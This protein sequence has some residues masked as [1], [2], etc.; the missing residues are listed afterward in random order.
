MNSFLKQVADHYYSLGDI[1]RRCFVFPNRRS[2]VFFSKYLC[3]AVRGKTPIVAPQMLTI[4]DMFYKVAGLFASDRVRLLLE[5]YE[6]YRELNPKAESLDEF[7]FWGDVILADF[8]DVDKYLVDPSQLFTNISDYKSLQDTFEY[9]TPTQKTAIE[10]FISHFN[11]KSGR[12]TVKLDTDNPDVKGRFLQIWNI[13]YP[14]YISFRETLRSK[15]MAYE[16]MV[17]KDLSDRLKSESVE[18]VFN[19]VFKVDA[20]FVFVGLNALS[21][22]EKMLL[23]K[24]RDAGRAQFCWDWSGDIIRDLQNRASFFMAD[25]VVEFPQAAQWDPEGVTVPTVNVV[26]VSSMIGQAKRLPDILGEIAS[27]RYSGDLSCIGSDCAVV[28][29][30]ENLL[31]PVLNSIPE[32][33]KDINVTMGLP[34][35]GSLLYALMSD[36][37]SVQLNVIRRKGKCWF[38][39]KHVWDVFSSEVFRKIA[40]QQTLDQIARVRAEARHYIPEDDFRNTPLLSAIFRPVVDDSKTASAE[41]IHSFAEYQKDVLR[42]LAQKLVDDSALALELEYAREYY[43]C[44]NVLQ[45]IRLEVLPVTYCRLLNQLL[46]AVSV[47]FNGEPLRGLQIMGPLEM[48]ALDFKDL[49]IMSANEGTFPRRSVSSSFVPPELRKG[50][51]MPTYEYQDAVWAYYFY[52][53]ISRAENVWMLVDSRTEG[54]KSGEESRYIKQLEYHFGVPI[55]RYVVKYDNMKTAQLS[56]IVKTDEDVQKVKETALSA[57][58]LQNYLACPAKFYYSTVKGLRADEE[59]AESLDYGMFGTIFH[60]TMRS[61]YTGEEAMNVDFFFDPRDSLRGL[62]EEPLKYVTREYIKSWLSRDEELRAK[63]KA[64]IMNEMNVLEISGRNLVVADV[65]LKYVKKTLN[66]DLELLRENDASHFVMH[67]LENRFARTMFGQ[68]FKGYIDR[69][70]SVKDGEVRVVDYKTGKVLENDENISDGNAVEI[71]DMI[72][73]PSCKER[74]KIALQFFIYDMLIQSDPRFEGLTIANSVYSTANL[75]KDKPQIKPLCRKFY[76]AMSEHMEKLLEEIYDLNVP[77]RR[78]DDEKVCAYC[79]FKMICGR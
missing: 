36:I 39:H 68:K 58:T 37:S 8:N 78:T 26:S 28:L 27:E 47:P 3:E 42:M 67:G 51:G 30:D 61:L 69:L 9:L 66:R 75:F 60:E 2:M 44:V 4:N 31:R 40:D 45:E 76:D 43:R 14:L 65:I 62:T 29:P 70:D 32:P 15:G 49:I 11:D 48:R 53:M 5:L 59:V 54:L 7:V 21:E 73:D 50:F 23:R 13:L 74:P 18:E 63:V 12:L 10:S 33:I 35:T 25:N 52:R 20:E 16:G 6:C 79:D 41:Q 38:Y 55:R 19:E 64:L 22:S 72:F 57:T 71:A 46:G 56:D 1:S 34:M 17:Y 77:F 24:L